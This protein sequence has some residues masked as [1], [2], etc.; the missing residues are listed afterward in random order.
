MKKMLL[1]ISVLL[2]SLSFFGQTL[3]TTAEVSFRATPESN[4]KVLCK[5]PKGTNIEPIEGIIPYKNWIAIEYKTKIGWVYQTYVKLK[6]CK[7]Q[8]KLKS[9]HKL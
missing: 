3:I 6:S 2:C 5:I 4:A 7:T 8:N 9:N 1:F